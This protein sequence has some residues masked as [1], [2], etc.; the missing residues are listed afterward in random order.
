MKPAPFQYHDPDTL[1]E[2]LHL[3]QQYGDEAKLIAGGQSLIPLLSMRLA[4]PA[5]L[6]DLKRLRVLDY[7]WQETAGDPLL[8][9][10]LTRQITL[11]DDLTLAVRQPLLA[12]TVPYIGHRAIRTRSTVGG[13][14]A[15]A[16]PAAEWPTLALLFGCHYYDSTSRA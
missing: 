6:I 5:V 12:A 3:L 7:Q 2:L 4:M 11:E 16:D 1:D 9:G 13:S 14:L 8:I 15:H 10:A